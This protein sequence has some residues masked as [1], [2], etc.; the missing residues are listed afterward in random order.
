MDA[1]KIALLSQETWI[2]FLEPKE[3]GKRFA[4]KGEVGRARVELAP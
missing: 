3:E 2:D 1:L 4:H